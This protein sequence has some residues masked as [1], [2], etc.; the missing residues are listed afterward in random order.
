MSARIQISDVLDDCDWCK[1]QAKYTQPLY[2]ADWKKNCKKKP[3]PLWFTM[4]GLGRVYG[5]YK[6]SISRSWLYSKKLGWI[7]NTPSY[8]G[9][10]YADSWGWIYIKDDMIYFFKDNRWDYLMNINS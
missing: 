4:K 3:K 7:Y 8:K 1:Q 5:T 2:F 10:F 9:Y 6:K